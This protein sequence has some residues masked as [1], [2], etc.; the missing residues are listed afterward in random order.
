MTY[1]VDPSSFADVV[2]SGAITGQYPVAVSSGGVISSS[3]SMFQPSGG[4]VSAS[5]MTFGGAARR[6]STT[7][8]VMV[9]AEVTISLDDAENGYTSIEVASAA[10][11]GW[12]EAA[13][14]GV[15]ANVIAFGVGLS[16]VFENILNAVVPAGYYY[17]LTQSGSGV[18]TL[19]STTEVFF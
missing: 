14:A 13:R 4:Y 17:R 1:H 16:F 15:D 19:I 8:P 2:A 11:G 6:P 10:S 3:G 12:F 18:N 5:G 7:R 9:F